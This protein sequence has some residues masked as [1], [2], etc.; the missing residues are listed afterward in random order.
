[1]IDKEAQ[2]LS[3]PHVVYQHRQTGWAMLLIGCIPAAGVALQFALVA[4]AQRSLPPAVFIFLSMAM[5]FVLLVFT[6]LSLT[7]TRDD[8]RVRFGIGIVRKT[9]ALDDIVDAVVVR[10]H[11]YEGW[12]IRRTRRGMLYNVAG[13]DAVR[14]R[15]RNGRA[16]IVGSDDA[17]RLAYAIRRTID[18]RRRRSRVSTVA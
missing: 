8:L 7:I 9:I 2:S 3:T 5:A 18:E 14:L 10:T 13:F 15:L 17:E 16:T 4:P 11:W 1:M 12:G 6:S